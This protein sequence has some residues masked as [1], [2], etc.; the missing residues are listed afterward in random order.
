MLRRFGRQ[1]REVEHV[2]KDIGFDLNS[3]RIF[4]VDVMKIATGEHLQVGETKETF[5]A[6]EAPIPKREAVSVQMPDVVEPSKKLLDHFRLVSVFAI[7]VSVVGVAKSRQFF[8]H[9]CFTVA[10]VVPEPFTAESDVT[11]AVE[12]DQFDDPCQ[13]LQ[14]VERHQERFSVERFFKYLEACCREI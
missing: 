2:S 13:M 10:K 5:L 8:S 1:L 6:E 3:S 12:S 4:G 7:D 9:N 14:N 11:D